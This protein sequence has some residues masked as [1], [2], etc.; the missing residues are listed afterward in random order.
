MVFHHVRQLPSPRATDGLEVAREIFMEGN[1]SASILT[2]VEHHIIP[3]QRRKSL[4]ELDRIN[5]LVCCSPYSSSL[6][7]V[8]TL[9]F[10]AKEELS[11]CPSGFKIFEGQVS[12]KTV[13]STPSY[14]FL[15][16][17]CPG[18]F[19]D[20]RY[21]ALYVSPSWKD[22]ISSQLLGHITLFLQNRKRK[23]WIMRRVN[24]SKN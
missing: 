9:S 13:P 12:M 20:Y 18:D 22:E 8:L 14:L 19:L 24:N 2:R 5:G 3:S 4:G 21:I 15:W 17:G 23:L 10:W 16:W 1:L 11:P 7:V 6:R